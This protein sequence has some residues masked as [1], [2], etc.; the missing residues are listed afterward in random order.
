MGA[1]VLSMP[2]IGDKFINTKGSWCEVINYEGH[3]KVTVR[4][5]D[6]Y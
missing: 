6:N 5:L 4:F 2:N 3:K 1:R